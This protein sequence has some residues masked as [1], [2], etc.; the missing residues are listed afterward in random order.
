MDKVRWVMTAKQPNP[1]Y[2]GLLFGLV[3]NQLRPE[4]MSV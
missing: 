3:L 1:D 4:V 2:D